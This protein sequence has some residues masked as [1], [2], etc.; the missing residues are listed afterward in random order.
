MDH[1]GRGLRAQVYVHRLNFIT[2][3][4][5]TTRDPLSYTACMKQAENVRQSLI[6]ELMPWALQG[7]AGLREWAQRVRKRYSEVWGDPADPAYQAK[8]QKLLD[9]WRECRAYNR[10]NR[11]RR[12][13]NGRAR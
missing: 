10:S 11:K 6:H 1:V 7:K 13:R 12:V 4:L 3:V 9:H 5:G 2:S 8:M